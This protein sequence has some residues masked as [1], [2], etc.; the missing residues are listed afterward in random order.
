MQQP[1]AVALDIFEQL[2][3]LV[4]ERHMPPMDLVPGQRLLVLPPPPPVRLALLR[5]EQAREVFLR[6][7]LP[8][9]PEH[10]DPADSDPRE[11]PLS[12]L[13]HLQR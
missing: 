3:P 11:Q 5:P 10:P 2:S 6:A 1:L 9:R 8:A 12:Q 4:L 7:H 13:L